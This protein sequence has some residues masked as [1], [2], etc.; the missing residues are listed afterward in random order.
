MTSDRTASGLEPQPSAEGSESHAPQN[1]GSSGIDRR[2]LLGSAAGALGGLWM[3]VPISRTPRALLA[4]EP[5][6]P[7][8]QTPHR[9]YLAPDDHTDYMW[10]ADEEGYARVFVET[11]DWAL[12]RADATAGAPAAHQARWNCD[13]SLW[14][15]TYER[16]RDQAA[17]LRLIE[18]IRDG[19]ISVPLNPLVCCYGGAPAEAVLRGMYYPG[20]IER[21]HGLRFALAH[22]VENQTLPAGLVSL[23]AGAGAR[24]SW[25]GICGCASKVED[26][27]DRLYDIYWWEG[28]DGRRLLMKWH[29]LLGDN[30]S[31]G[32]Y[33]EARMPEEAVRL[34]TDDARTS[35]FAAR[36]PYK[37]IG[38]FGQGWDDLQTQDERVRDAAV[39]LTDREREVIVSNQEDFF[40]DFE[41]T[42][43]EGLPRWS[44]AFGNEWDLLVA[45]MAELTARVRRATEALRS[46]EALAT[47]ACRLDASFMD[48]RET[49]R[50]Q[51]FMDL[52]LYWEHDWTANG[53]VAR[54]ARAAWQRALAER[55]EGYV[56]GLRADATSVVSAAIP[57]GDEPRVAAFNP[58]GWTRDGVLEVPW[59]PIAAALGIDPE[60]LRSSGAEA[61][62][63]VHAIVVSDGT[64][65]R[66]DDPD[67]R[68]E[69]AFGSL[70]LQPVRRDGADWL[71]LWV[72]RVPAIGYRLVAFR[73]GPAPGPVRPPAAV[74]TGRT[75]V[76]DAFQLELD[77]HGRITQ[78]LD[79][80]RGNRDLVRE[81]DGRPMNALAPGERAGPGIVEVE[82]I[83]PVSVTLRA[84]SDTPLRHVT[85][86]TLY[87]GS[88]RMDIENTITENFAS[89]YVWDFGFN[90][91][92]AEVWHE[93]V[94]AL[95]KAR[96]ETDGGHYAARNARY[97]WMSLGHFAAIGNATHWAVLSNADCAFFRVG[98]STADHLDDRTP[99]LSV[100]A[101]GQVDG[102]E[103]GIP[104]QG[105]DERFTQRFAL[106]TADRYDP[107]AAMRGALEHQNPLVA[108]AATGE[109]GPLPASDWSWMQIDERAVLLW[110][111]KPGED[112]P[113]REVIARAWNLG[114]RRADATVRIT[115]PWTVR[116]ATRTTHI[117]TPIADEP[118]GGEGGEP[119]GVAAAQAVR[120]AVRVG[121]ETGAMETWRM[122]VGRLGVEDPGRVAYL[123][124]VR[125]D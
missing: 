61:P 21:R 69:E 120:G 36:Y 31:S 90:L 66:A 108:I 62:L 103:L 33:A 95:L 73:A 109:R 88:P 91:D 29:S 47:I 49:V 20:R 93:E 79:R 96:L 114:A 2:R 110:A 92:G 115:P 13:G 16:Q 8:L 100:L 42:Y 4:R 119:A 124:V 40:R 30:R 99:R 23:F 37:V 55:I 51:A 10:S 56:D 68:E 113:A 26:A 3:G 11:L 111:L 6:Q 87:A 70:A 41:A 24:W 112:D 104:D 65:G 72:P 46:A 17:F 94:G 53:P 107:V 80:A 9:V 52:G 43:G 60:A 45:S 85:R 86:I 1:R 14:M 121:L 32:G 35:G 5:L 19:H 44:G 67:E 15:W 76:S 123:P 63:P 22:S 57:A 74:V 34:V 101:G 59:A 116:E 48:S 83:G 12:D 125:K 98:R 64:D 89:T 77:E 84:A 106:W 54:S 78:L 105:G 71:R 97:D 122:R 82:S 102:P 28:K 27:G 25:K 75:V 38:L 81:V 7:P 50:D 117:E 18:R 58:L 39:A 118:T